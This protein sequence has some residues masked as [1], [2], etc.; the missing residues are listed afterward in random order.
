M[1]YGVKRQGKK[2]ITYNTETGDVKGTHG[3][4]QDAMAQKQLLYAKKHGWSPGGKRPARKYR[5]KKKKK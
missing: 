1:P 5:Y 3:T 4:Y 2:W